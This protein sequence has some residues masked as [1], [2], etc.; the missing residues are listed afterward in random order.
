MIMS[1]IGIIFTS[2]SAF[3][4]LTCYVTDTIPAKWPLSPIS[5]DENPVL[6]EIVTNIF[7]GIGLAGIVILLAGFLGFI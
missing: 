1:V 3:G 4:L 5:R 6:F 7:W 2:F